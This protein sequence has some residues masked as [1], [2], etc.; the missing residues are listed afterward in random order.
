MG[1]N[2]ANRARAQLSYSVDDPHDPAVPRRVEPR[3]MVHS[4]IFVSPVVAM[5]RVVPPPPPTASSAIR[6]TRPALS[7]AI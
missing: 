1:V 4:A 7:P 6:R 5:R 3:R 2:V